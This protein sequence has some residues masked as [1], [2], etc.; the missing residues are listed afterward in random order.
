MSSVVFWLYLVTQT[1]LSCRQRRHR[2]I[3]SCACHYL[4][5][6]SYQYFSVVLFGF[7]SGSPCN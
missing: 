6:K 1:C 5:F 3:Q 2:I 4:Y 7:L